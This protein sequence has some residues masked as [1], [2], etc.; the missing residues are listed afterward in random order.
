MNPRK[1]FGIFFLTTVLGASASL[2]T[3]VV[4]VQAESRPAR[5]GAGGLPSMSIG[6]LQSPR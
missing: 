6:S 2:F 1:S 3:F 4:D 5:P